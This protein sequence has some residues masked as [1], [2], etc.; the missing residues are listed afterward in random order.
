MELGLVF[1]PA[2]IK[3]Q[4]HRFQMSSPS[5]MTGIHIKECFGVWRV[6]G[7]SLNELIGIRPPVQMKFDHSVDRNPMI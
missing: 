1:R 7:H 3:G 6:N 5:V 4:T 2:T